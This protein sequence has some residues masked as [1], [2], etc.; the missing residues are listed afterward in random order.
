MIILAGIS[1]H[2]LFS[3]NGIFQRTKEQKEEQKRAQILE[4]LELTK[5]ALMN[6]SIKGF[7]FS[8][9]IPKSHNSIP[10]LLS[11]N[12]IGILFLYNYV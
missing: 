9:F 5:K 12:L 11:H 8:F 4:E 7:L 3:E 10:F 1:I 2:L 6:F